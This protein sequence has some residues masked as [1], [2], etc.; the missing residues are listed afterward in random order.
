MS[1]DPLEIPDVLKPIENLLKG[2]AIMKPGRVVA[3]LESSDVVKA[4]VALKARYGETGLYFSTLVA[5]DLKE[6]GKIRIDYYI[7]VLEKNQYVVLR[8]HVPRDDPRIE[9]LLKEAP[10][11]LPG[12]CE[13]YDLLGVIF[14]GNPHLRRAF[15]VPEEVAGKGIF[16]L[17]KDAGV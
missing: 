8:T 7:N 5:T 13:A 6:E 12:E 11:A 14:E 4:Y 15:F 9:S 16:P 1:S 17:R 3:L 10:A 2:V